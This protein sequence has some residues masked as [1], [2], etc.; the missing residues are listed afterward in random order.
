MILVCMYECVCVS[1]SLEMD[2]RMDGCMRTSNKSNRTHSQDREECAVEQQTFMQTHTHVH[3]HRYTTGTT[4][5]RT[6]AQLY[7]HT[8]AQSTRTHAQAL[9]LCLS[10]ILSHIHR[11]TFMPSA[12][13]RL[14]KML[15]SESTS[16]THERERKPFFLIA[17]PWC[18]S[19]AHSQQL[20][21]TF[22]TSENS[23]GHCY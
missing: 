22:C 15:V 19:I 21:H 6:H 18:F 20:T 2:G 9:C 5:T 23:L 10:H 8:D 17:S 3:A 1:P 14:V 16:C 13:L 12:T 4:C 11:Y 7:H